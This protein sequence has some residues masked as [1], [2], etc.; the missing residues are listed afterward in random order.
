[1]SK[2]LQLF[3]WINE[4]TAMWKTFICVQL[5]TN[6]ELLREVL[7]GYIHLKVKKKRFYFKLFLKRISYNNKKKR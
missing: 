6:A 2:I 1:M 5:N 4:A 7:S 3:Y